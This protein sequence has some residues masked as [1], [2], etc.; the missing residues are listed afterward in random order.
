MKRST[1]V[2][3]TVAASLVGAAGA[4]VAQRGKVPDPIPVEGFEQLL[5][6]GAIE[7]LVDPTFVPAAKADIPEDAWVLGFAQGGQA[8]AYDLN[9]L[10]SH[11][12]VNHQAG[13]APIAAVW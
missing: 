11:E 6:R 4:A 10:N 3:G 9:L 8:Y 1:I 7:A 12:V 13:G 5:P 2:W